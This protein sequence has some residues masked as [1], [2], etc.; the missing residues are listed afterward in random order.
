MS[1]TQGCSEQ[2]RV[3]NVETSIVSNCAIAQEAIGI[4]TI[5]VVLLRQ[6]Y[7]QPGQ[8]Q[9]RC[10]R[11]DLLSALHIPAAGQLTVPQEA[12]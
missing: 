5:S 10:S 7:K 2:C 8:M 11:C 12:A 3:G 1:E 4:H 9:H 6:C